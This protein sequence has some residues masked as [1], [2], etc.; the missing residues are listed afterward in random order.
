MK[1]TEVPHHCMFTW[2]EGGGTAGG[3]GEMGRGFGGR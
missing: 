1:E 2:K 3:D